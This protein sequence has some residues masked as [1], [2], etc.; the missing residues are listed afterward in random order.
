MDNDLLLTIADDGS[1]FDSDEDALAASS[2]GSFGLVGMRER[3]RL[4]GA[5]LEV[6]SRRA[7]GTRISVRVPLEPHDAA[8]S[9]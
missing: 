1:G 3:A 6:T 9:A 5:H 8:A 2:P 7:G 4:I